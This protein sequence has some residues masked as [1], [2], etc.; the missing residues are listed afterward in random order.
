MNDLL[1]EDKLNLCVDFS[2]LANYVALPGT[3]QLVDECE[4]ELNWVPFV[5]TAKKSPGKTQAGDP[6]L[7][8]KARRA[9]ARKMFA[10]KELQRECELLGIPVEAGGT[11]FDQRAA[12]MG[13]LLLREADADQSQYWQYVEAIFSAA[14]RDLRPVED[15]DEIAGLLKSLGVMLSLPLDRSEELAETQDQILEA[16]VFES[17]TFILKGERFLGRQHL[18]LLTWMLKGRI[19]LPPV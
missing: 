5:K 3:R 1:S 9:R 19:G 18:P 13:L 17:P 12:A 10:D 15:L 2:S 16:G 14:F 6:L 4:I 7:E 8:Y 11:K